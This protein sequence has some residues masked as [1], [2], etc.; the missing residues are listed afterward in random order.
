M[1]RKPWLYKKGDVP[2][3][4]YAF[5]DEFDAFVA[6]MKERGVTDAAVVVGAFVKKYGTTCVTE[7]GSVFV[8]GPVDGGVAVET[9]DGHIHRTRVSRPFVKGAS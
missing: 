9:S 6:V 2:E 8:V 3:E 7:T 5:L 4:K 1:V